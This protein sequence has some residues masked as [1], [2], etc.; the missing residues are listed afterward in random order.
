MEWYKKGIQLMN[1]H[2]NIANKLVLT[3]LF[4]ATLCFGMQQHPKHPVTDVALRKCI[5]EREE[6]REL[7]WELK[8]EMTQL[9]GYTEAEAVEQVKRLL[10]YPNPRAQFLAELAQLPEKEINKIPKIPV[11]DEPVTDPDHYVYDFS[12]LEK[13]VRMVK[14]LGESKKLASVDLSY[15]GGR[16]LEYNHDIHRSYIKDN[17]ILFAPD[18]L[19]AVLTSQKENKNSMGILLH[20]GAYLNKPN[21]VKFLLNHSRAHE[22]SKE[23][24][25]IALAAAVKADYQ[26]VVDLLLN[27]Q[28]NPCAH[29]IIGEYNYMGS[30]VNSNKDS[31]VLG[32]ILR[33]AANYG[34]KGMVEKFLNNY[35]TTESLYYG[36]N[37]DYRSI[38]Y[39]KANNAG[40]FTA[41][42][43]AAY[44]GHKELVAWLLNPLTNPRAAQIN[45]GELG[46][47]LRAA[48]YGG[49]KELVAWLLNPQTNPR[50]HE[51]TDGQGGWTVNPDFGIIEATP[52]G[53]LMRP[54][55]LAI[56][57]GHPELAMWFVNPQTNPFPFASQINQGYVLEI[58]VNYGCYELVDW[59][60]NPQ[61][62][63]RSQAI[64]AEALGNAL[65]H[66][67]R[68]PNLEI[69]R[70]ILT[71]PRARE[72]S[73]FW[74][75][76]AYNRMQRCNYNQAFEN[77]ERLR[78][79]ILS[80][81]DQHGL[82]PMQES[83]RIRRAI[84][85]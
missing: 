7:R 18:I 1:K 70:R 35:H 30:L 77:N 20:I 40:I 54:I 81:F 53:N 69:I 37:E 19:E 29:M 8:S 17:K 16:I 75:G 63:P 24:L 45:A 26:E 51:L 79:E 6:T 25:F 23:Q 38:N 80:L 4:S 48:A 52:V 14:M 43:G 76:K 55:Q 13:E 50:A 15:G 36:R 41:L 61:T 60:L 82:R 83:T 78:T 73:N 44:G 12:R 31:D 3:A 11:Q 62:N 85:P 68:Q 34:H 39:H 21:S 84:A 65:A 64:S 22:L 33:I 66:T 5:D 59:L 27:S 32:A 46:R 28:S 72:I 57:G 42:N 58:A 10:T 67:H 47:A 56:Q 71:D 74:K 9:L 49:Q 2:S